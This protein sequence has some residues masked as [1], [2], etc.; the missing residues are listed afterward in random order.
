[1]SIEELLQN[2]C[3]FWN[4]CCS[5]RMLR[6]KLISNKSNNRK[7]KKFLKVIIF[8]NCFSSLCELFIY[9]F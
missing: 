4:F 9:Y 2:F 5:F 3:T 6:L 8:E 7:L 1:M